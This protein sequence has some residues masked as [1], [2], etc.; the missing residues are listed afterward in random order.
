M[1]SSYVKDYKISKAIHEEITA[2]IHSDKDVANYFYK[3]EMDVTNEL[4]NI[5]KEYFEDNNLKEKTHI[6]IG[7]IDNLCHEI[8]FHKHDELNY[9]IITNLVI[10][11]IISFLKS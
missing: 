5:L 2:M 7:M 10:E 6:I 11:N 3:R 9:V 1:I 8:V 4:Y